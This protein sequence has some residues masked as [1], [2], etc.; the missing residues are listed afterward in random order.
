MAAPHIP[1]EKLHPGEQPDT[2]GYC[3]KETDELT[4]LADP[5]NSMG[6]RSWQCNDCNPHTNDW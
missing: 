3:G 2:C 1:S 4:F 5:P 6:R